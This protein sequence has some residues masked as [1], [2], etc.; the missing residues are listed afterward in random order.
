MLNTVN[1]IL[2]GVAWIDAFIGLLVGFVVSL[3]IFHTFF[4][5]DNANPNYGEWST[6]IIL[7]GLPMLIFYL[8]ATVFAIKS[9]KGWHKVKP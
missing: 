3:T 1:Y 5:P 7:F 4:P 2:K 6:V 9:W 8:L